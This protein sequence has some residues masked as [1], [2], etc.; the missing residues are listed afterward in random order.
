MRCR[1]C[2]VVLLEVVPVL[3]KSLAVVVATRLSCVVLEDS[4]LQVI[5]TTYLAYIRLLLLPLPTFLA[6]PQELELL[7]WGTGKTVPY[8]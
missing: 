1:C 4:V 6:D 2:D 8:L 3:W 5:R 7:I